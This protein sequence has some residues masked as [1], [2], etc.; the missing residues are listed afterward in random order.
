MVVSNEKGLL[1]TFLHY[2]APALS[3]IAEVARESKGWQVLV[4]LFMNKLSKFSCHLAG[5][6]S[7]VTPLDN[8][9][10]FGLTQE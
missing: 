9:E 7:A 4:Y 6:K 10:D 3:S 8:W 5:S 2:P 1:W